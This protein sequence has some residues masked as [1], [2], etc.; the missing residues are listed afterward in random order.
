[1]M[2]KNIPAQATEDYIRRLIIKR[3]KDQGI[4]IPADDKAMATIRIAKDSDGYN[5]GM[6]QLVS[7]NKDCIIQ[8]IKLHKKQWFKSCLATYLSGF[9]YDD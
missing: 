3:M 7:T 6:A 5:T 1:M 4:E 8:A 2:I 9:T